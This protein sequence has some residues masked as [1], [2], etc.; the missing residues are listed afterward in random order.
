MI[1]L[2]DGNKLK[3][4]LRSGATPAASMIGK[5]PAPNRDG[6]FDNGIMAH[7]YGHGISNRLTGGPANGG[8][9]LNT[10]GYET[11]GEGWSDFLGL[12]MTTKL[13]DKGETARG[14]GTYVTYE[15][16]TGLGIRRKPYST[17]FA[18]NNFTYAQLGTS[19]GKF[20]ETHDVGEVWCSMLW[21]LN[22]AL[23]KKYTYEP[24]L[25]AA[26]GGNNIALKLVMDGMKLQP[27][28][29]GF[30]DGRNA[31]LKA[32]TLYNK[33]ANASLIWQVFARR[34]LGYSAVQGSS[35][36]VND[37][38]AAFD[39]PPGVLATQKQLS[40]D[41]LAIYPN[42]ASSQLTVR[43]LISSRTPVQVSLL[44]VLGKTVQKTEV[45]A[46]VMQQQGVQLN[47]SSLAAGLY[48]VKINTSAGIVTKKV[49]I[50]H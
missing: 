26:I 21:D 24:D 3:A 33:A 34:G 13:G 28:T 19:A 17:D 14:V 23:I 49:L 7:E 5:V 16:T 29:P 46:A 20:S 50:Q 35:K 36:S 1:S 40:E 22:W 45:P 27:C 6:D 4:S 11:M 9:L 31:I 15:T 42:P 18:V 47:T 2:A 12:W 10:N 41:L 43:T 39:L 37:N 38:T 32:D 8:C 25:K 44:T 30:V 48:L